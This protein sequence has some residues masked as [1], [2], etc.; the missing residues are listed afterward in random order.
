MIEKFVSY[1]REIG[2][3]ASS[4]GFSNRGRYPLSYYADELEKAELI[5][6]KAYNTLEKCEN[7]YMYFFIEK[8]MEIDPKFAEDQGS[9]WERVRM[10]WDREGSDFRLLYQACATKHPELEPVSELFTTLLK[11]GKVK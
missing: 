5:I 3:W 8:T 10:G 1:I 6:A 9:R 2:K 7:A 11:Y 4:H